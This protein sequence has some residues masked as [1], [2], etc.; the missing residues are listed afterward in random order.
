M[1]EKQAQ[2]GYRNFVLFM[3]LLVYTLNYLDRQ[4]LG[5]LAMPI[6]AELA[7]TDSQLG[8]LGGIAFA[9]LYT[10]LSVPLAMLADRTNRTWVITVSLG[11]W[12]GFTALCGLAGSFTSLFLCRLGVG[13]GEAGG[14]APSYAVIGD[15]FPAERQGR[16]FSIYSLG[17]PLGSAAG[18]LLGGTLAA[19]VEWRTAFIVVGLAGLLFA[20]I[21]RLLV[22]EPVRRKK[23]VTISIGGTFTLLARLPAF[24]L[25]A[26][27]VASAS[28][29]IYGTSFWLPSLL[30]RSF[31]LDL[32]Q[33]GYFLGILLL[34]SGVGGV[35]L[36]GW[37][38]DHF[39]AHDRGNYVRISGISY[40]SFV[41]LF[42]IGLLSSTVQAAF[43][44][45]LI[46]QALL[47]LSLSPSMVAVQNLVPAEMRATAAAIFLLITNLIGL[48]TGSWLIGLLS[49]ALSP[50]F[51]DDA[52]RY[53]MVSIL[54][55]FLVAGCLM[56]GAARHV[57]T[58]WMGE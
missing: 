19:T 16:A 4:I 50:V 54:T 1:I 15:Y 34:T 17:V 43:L 37:L 58:A 28:A 12:S 47:Y 27:G 20:P 51:G 31:G 55:L 9:A 44:F 18:V 26:A 53:A 35:L 7:L 13:V 40:L 32:R 25:I 33:T 30:Q 46:P 38:A 3:L 56:L 39:G 48:G 52:L 21:F 24:W 42:A 11:V 36:G 14:V 57:R 8:L 2:T 10:T 5:I 23:G 41:P 29:A 49:D 45:M 6:K 22:R